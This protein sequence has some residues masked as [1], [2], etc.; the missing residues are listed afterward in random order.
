MLETEQIAKKLEEENL[1]RLKIDEEYSEEMK[2]GICLDFM[3][4][5]VTAMPC[6]HNV[7]SVVF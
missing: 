7:F 4:Q 2:C 5:T 6:L 3:Y 1:K